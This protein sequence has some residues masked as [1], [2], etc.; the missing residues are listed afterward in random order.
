MQNR[1]LQVAPFPNLSQHTYD[2]N[3]IRDDTQELQQ[4]WDSDYVN[5]VI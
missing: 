5:Y 1:F 3:E 2:E 4:T